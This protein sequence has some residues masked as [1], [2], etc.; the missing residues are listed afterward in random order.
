MN[1]AKLRTF[2]ARQ[3][4]FNY[5]LASQSF[6]AL[7]SYILPSVPCVNKY[8]PYTFPSY[9]LSCRNAYPPG[10]A[11]NT[12]EMGR[13]QA[14]KGRGTSSPQISLQLSPD[15]LLTCF[16]TCATRRS[17]ETG[18]VG[19]SSDGMQFPSFILTSLAPPS[20]CWLETST[21]T[22]VDNYFGGKAT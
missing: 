5:F 13:Q 8:V 4:T 9:Q 11:G 18:L 20:P 22:G 7:N 19:D 6:S 16:L 10:M 2:R 17:M 1:P 15:N 14:H 12:G 21:R 3:F